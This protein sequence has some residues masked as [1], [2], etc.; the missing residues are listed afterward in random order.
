M[1]RGHFR[2]LDGTPKWGG[3]LSHWGGS[4]TTHRSRCCGRVVPGGPWPAAAPPPPW[5]RGRRT[6]AARRRPPPGAAPPDRGRAGAVP[7]PPPKSSWVLGGVWVP[8]GLR[9]SPS[10]NRGFGPWR[11]QIPTSD[12]RGGEA[13]LFKKKASTSLAGGTERPL[14]QP[15]GFQAL[16]VLQQP[17]VERPQPHLGQQA[18]PPPRPSNQLTRRLGCHG[19]WAHIW[20]ADRGRGPTH[21]N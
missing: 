15:P 5:R 18:P 7:A 11:C 9:R 2:N 20:L 1:R 6:A 16:R 21:F 10:A 14:L 13:I 8:C 19:R 17:A 12:G 4:G 3:A